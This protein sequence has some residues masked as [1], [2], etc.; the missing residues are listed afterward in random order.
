MATRTDAEL[1]TWLDDLR[2]D[3]AQGNEKSAALAQAAEPFIAALQA[4]PPCDY[5]DKAICKATDAVILGYIA[6]RT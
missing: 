2:A 5:R 6:A 1:Q 4:M 3:A